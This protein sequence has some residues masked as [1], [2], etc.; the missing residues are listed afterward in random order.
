LRLPLAA[1]ADIPAW[2]PAPCM[3]QPAGAP[4]RKATVLLIEDNADSREMIRI[5]LEMSGYVVLEAE[6][7]ALGLQLALRHV[8]DAAVIDVGLPDMD[9][10]AVAR[11]IRQ[12]PLAQGAV[13]MHLIALTGYGQEDDRNRAM[14]A[15]FDLH[16]VKPL[17]IARLMAAIDGAAALPTPAS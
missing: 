12:R 14:L 7:G 4:V 6:N 15:G 9:G 10:Y 17:D 1:E 3:A 5:L 16:L 13:P 8:P 2:P 11:A